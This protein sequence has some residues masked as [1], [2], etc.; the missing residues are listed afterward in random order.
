MG[1]DWNS[2]KVVELKEE[3]KK[4]GLPV[5]GKKAEL[6]SRLEDAEGGNEVSIIN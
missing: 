6:I 4:R 3:L 1:T 5:S 2:L